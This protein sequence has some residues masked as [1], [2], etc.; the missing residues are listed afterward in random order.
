VTLHLNDRHA[1]LIVK[2]TSAAVAF[3]LTISL[4]GVSASA[5]RHKRFVITAS[6]STSRHHNHY[7]CVGRYHYLV[8][9]S[10]ITGLASSE[11]IITEYFFQDIASEMPIK[12]LAPTKP[13]A[14]T[15]AAE[16]AMNGELSKEKVQSPPSKKR[17]A[18]SSSPP[19]PSAKAPKSRKVAAPTAAKPRRSRKPTQTAQT[20]KEEPEQIAPPPPPPMLSPPLVHKVRQIQAFLESSKGTFF[21]REDPT[22]TLVT[23]PE[24][25]LR[26]ALTSMRFHWQIGD[27]E[28][29]SIYDI[30]E[31]LVDTS[32]HRPAGTSG[33]VY[34]RVTFDASI[35]TAFEAEIKA[36]I[37]P[38]LQGVSLVATE[39]KLMMQNLLVMHGIKEEE[40]SEVYGKLI[41][42][43]VA[44][45]FPGAKTYTR[46]DSGFGQA[47]EG[48]KLANDEPAD[49]DQA[50]V[51]S[52]SP[53]EPTPSN[54]DLAKEA[55]PS[56]LAAVDSGTTAKVEE[57][58]K[59]N[60]LDVAD[61]EVTSGAKTAT[62]GQAAV[63][64][65]N[66]TTC[67]PGSVDLGS[68]GEATESTT[69]FRESATVVEESE[70]GIG[71]DKHV[72]QD[73]NNSVDVADDEG[74][75][76]AKTAIDGETMEGRGA[77][78]R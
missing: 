46:F 39:L 57:Q 49:D 5:H 16:L 26:G 28:Q 75:G 78:R 35:P 71:Q 56:E 51:R 3:L 74:A 55:G 32:V 59:N 70:E 47:M 66:P 40:K 44:S 67:V 61:D 19:S 64:G 62:D 48:E 22:A 63:K 4:F 25:N 53:A 8:S 73:K 54:V 12:L 72:E 45:S 14:A 24:M 13:E 52:E 58:G 50:A 60:S 20:V 2:V 42:F 15:S 27:S 29:S 33:V 9:Y 11:H 65:E 37:A 76:D 7:S 18:A 6:T 41:D 38:Y 17:K 68:E 1:Q 43:D 69:E 77:G 23:V 30:H 10:T 36:K 31:A 21:D 34:Q